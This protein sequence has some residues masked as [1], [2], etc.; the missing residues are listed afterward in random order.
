MVDKVDDITRQFFLE[1]DSE[2][3]K[4]IYEWAR[5]RYAAPWAVF[6]AVLLRVAASI[7]HR[8]QLPGVIGG[9]ASLNLLCAFVSISGG[10]KG[11]SDQV[12]RL[13]WPTPITEK[14]IGTGE[15]IAAV[16]MPP[17]KPDENNEPVTSVIFSCSEIDILTGIATRQGSTILGT[18]KAFAMG[19]LLGSTNA[20]KATSRLV[21]AHTYRGCLSVGAQPGH[22]GI[23]F[24]DTTG[25]SPQRFL[26]APA[27]DPNMPTE[28]IP[29]P[30]PLNTDIPFW[31]P[32]GDGVV[33]ISYGP[34]EI[35][36]SIISA[37][38]ARQRG[39][40]DALDGHW[41]LTRCKVAAL[42]AVMHQRSVVSQQHWE[43]SET[44][45]AVSDNTRQML[46]DHSRKA[47]RAK[48][49]ERALSRAAGEEIIDQRRLDVVKRRVLKVL[50]DGRIARGDLRARMG[51]KEYRE[52]LEAATAELA[53]D[54]LIARVNATQGGVQFELL[55][56]FSPEPQ[57]SPQNSS[58]DA[59]NREFSPEPAAD[60]VDLDS[61]RSPENSGTKLTAREWLGN[62]I[63]DLQNA[64]HTT[65]KSLAVYKAARAA[66]FK[67]TNVAVA[68]GKHPDIHVIDRK[69][70]TATWSITPGQQPPA[71]YQP[72]A[73]WFDLWLDQQTSDRVVPDDARI[74]GEAAGHSWETVR[75]TAAF[76]ERITSVPANGVARNDRIW[77][78]QPAQDEGTA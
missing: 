9:R 77:L 28:R 62:H 56:E 72:V 5:A 43:L 12:G 54:G 45:M 14:P 38:I 55:P 47:V 36:E 68:A 33:E 63:A 64:G 78:L 16:F 53:A 7:D 8:V 44:V 4:R 75:R 10:G 65:I 57:F 18:L 69:G 1:S 13:A 27:F 67:K 51:K 23:I 20:S 30:A 59:L 32:G 39:H 66:G 76:S 58:S 21:K 3:L 17:D 29:D 74:A 11:I 24:D 73:E 15:G 52:L 49:Q 41:M 34:D 37:H 2:Q 25:G 70:G 50:Q 19:E 61:R 31:A 60:I 6:F 48:I 26:W 42:I 46:I 71:K 22:T 40:G 35:T